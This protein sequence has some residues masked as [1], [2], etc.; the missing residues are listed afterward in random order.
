MVTIQK[1]ICVLLLTLSIGCTQNTSSVPKNINNS[2]VNLDHALSLVDST[3]IDDQSMAYI[4][5]YAEV[6]DY[7]PVQAVGEGIACVDDVGRFIEGL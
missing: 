3:F 4:L 6:P 1:F 2:P 7:E 5:I